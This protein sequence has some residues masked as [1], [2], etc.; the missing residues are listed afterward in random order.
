MLSCVYFGLPHFINL[1]CFHW[2]TEVRSDSVTC[3]Y[4]H[5]NLEHN[6]YIKKLSCCRK[7]PYVPWRCQGAGLKLLLNFFQ[8]N[9][10][11]SNS[12]M[13]LSME[14]LKEHPLVI[15]NLLLR[16][17]LCVKWLILWSRI[18]CKKLIFSH[19]LKD[20]FSKWEKIRLPTF[21]EQ[22]AHCCTHKSWSLCLKQFRH[23][24]LS[25]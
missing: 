6:I 8:N 15:V 10:S 23:F 9:S 22:N 21:M 14:C 4:C 12:R 19:V 2:L 17:P 24:H 25:L 16:D 5:E 20:F 7:H 3:S 11:S 1:M 18:F 13:N